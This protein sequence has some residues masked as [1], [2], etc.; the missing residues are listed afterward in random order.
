MSADR[1]SGDFGSTLRHA[2]E[3]RGVSLRTIAD[4]TKI[5]VSVLEALERNDLS[6]LPG[7]I[8]SRAFVRAYAAA[9]GLDV[10]AT[11]DDFVRHFPHDTVTAGH[12]PSRSEDGDSFE[13]DRR[14]AS[15][16]LKLF[17]ASVP[18][19]AF[20]FY[21][22]LPRDP[23][24]SVA[25]A[26]VSRPSASQAVRSAPA[27]QTLTVDVVADKQCLLSVSI[28]GQALVD[29]PL[30]AS[31]RRSFEA[32]REV[33]LTVSDGSAV[34]VVINGVPARALGPS[35]MTATARITTDNF[36]EFADQR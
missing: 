24:G 18:I 27:A 2:R 3:R 36:R 32:S 5:S 11:V 34:R 25:P 29:V 35:G 6:R 26:P 19:L 33:L 15:T 31:D 21:I 22:G 8:F 13:S 4:E 7:G 1:K 23:E 10:E 30:I 9:V 28:D 12:P 14:A 20:L 17:A 16:A